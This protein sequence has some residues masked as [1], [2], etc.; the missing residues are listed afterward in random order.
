MD[1]LKRRLT[2]LRD[3][4]SKHH[5]NM[6]DKLPTP[7]DLDCNEK[8]KNM[9]HTNDNCN[10]ATKAQR[11]IIDTVGGHPIHCQT[12]L[13]NTVLSNP[14]I[15][16][17]NKIVKDEIDNLDEVDSIFRVSASIMA[18]ARAFDKGTALPETTPRVTGKS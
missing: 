16:S 7:A 18:L 3:Y 6:V 4:V 11:L 12:H 15:R 8:M 14:T 13:R 1:I 10:T 17:L 9:K 5:P 2:D